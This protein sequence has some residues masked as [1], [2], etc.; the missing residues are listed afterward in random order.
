MQILSS[1]TFL[2]T[3]DFHQC[4]RLHYRIQVVGCRE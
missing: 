2:S 4:H 1:S 3:V